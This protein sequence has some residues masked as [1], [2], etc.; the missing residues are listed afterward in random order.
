MLLEVDNVGRRLCSIVPER[1][2]WHV[3]GI[4]QNTHKD[5]SVVTMNKMKNSKVENAG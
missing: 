1:L 3:L 2:V 5:S 4:K